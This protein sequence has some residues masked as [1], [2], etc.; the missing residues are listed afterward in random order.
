[1][2]LLAVLVA[3]VA[4]FVLSSAYYIAAG[5]RLAALSPAYA[6]AERTPVWIAPVELG[7]SAVVALVLAGLAGQLGVSGPGTAVMLGLILWI[8][9][10]AVL[11]TGSVVHEKVPWRLA[12]IHAGDWLLKLLLITLIVSLWR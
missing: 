9:F 2:N 3:T 1:M 7:R 5:S 10:P 4:A 11:L 6:S 12:A 8:G